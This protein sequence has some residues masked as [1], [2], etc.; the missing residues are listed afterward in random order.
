MERSMQKV[1]KWLQNLQDVA[2]ERAAFRVWGLGPGFRE[3]RAWALGG[4]GSGFRLGGR[5]EQLYAM[6]PT[7][8]T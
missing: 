2:H 5:L 7:P 3:L 8:W 1:W 6:N 4:S